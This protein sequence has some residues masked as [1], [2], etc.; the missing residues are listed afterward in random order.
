MSL[1]SSSHSHPGGTDGVTA[2]TANDAILG[3]VV[4]NKTSSQKRSSRTGGSFLGDPPTSSSIHSMTSNS[5]LAT[6]PLN[7]SGFD[8]DCV[9]PVGDTE[10]SAKDW[11]PP[12]YMTLLRVGFGVAPIL[13]CK[14]WLY[15][16]MAAHT[17][18]L[19]ECTVK[20]VA[21]ISVG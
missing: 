21:C 12:C 3:N 9:K 11:K 2:N 7:D 19:P 17:D 13:I 15:T 16:C 1:S 4:S 6:S 5:V 18:V 20:L 14:S 10:E 8:I